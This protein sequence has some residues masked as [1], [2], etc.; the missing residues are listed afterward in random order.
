[1]VGRHLEGTFIDGTHLL[2][3]SPVCTEKPTEISIE[4]KPTGSVK[5]ARSQSSCI[6]ERSSTE[7]IGVMGAVKLRIIKSEKTYSKFD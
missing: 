4:F 6:S 3:M 7:S 5:R 2:V 1:M